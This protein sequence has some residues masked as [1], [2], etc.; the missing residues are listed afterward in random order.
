VRLVLADDH[1]VDVRIG[2]ARLLFL[3]VNPA[4]FLTPAQ[5]RA[6]KEL[7][8]LSIVALYPAAFLDFLESTVASCFFLSTSCAST[9]NLSCTI[10]VAFSNA[11]LASLTSAW[12]SCEGV[13]PWLC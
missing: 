2:E 4:A 9:C 11:T 10:L 3:A 6:W 7:L 12:A 13:C 1:V 5:L 8:P